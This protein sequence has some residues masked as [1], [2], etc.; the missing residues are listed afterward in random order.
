MFNIVFLDN[1]YFISF[2]KKIDYY[3]W[4]LAYE[5]LKINIDINARKQIR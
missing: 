2:F 3:F 5:E 4:L 1:H